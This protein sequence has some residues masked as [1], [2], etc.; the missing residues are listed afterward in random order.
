MITINRWH[1]SK[2]RCVKFCDDEGCHNSIYYAGV[3]IRH[4]TASGWGTS[5]KKNLPNAVISYRVAVSG[6]RISLSNYV[7]YN[8]IRSSKNLFR[9]IEIFHVCLMIQH[10]ASERTTDKSRY[11]GAM[12]SWNPMKTDSTMETITTDWL[13]FFVFN[14]VLHRAPD[15]H[16]ISRIAHRRH[17]QEKHCQ[18]EMTASDRCTS[19]FEIDESRRWESET[20]HSTACNTSR[21]RIPCI[22]YYW[23]CRVRTA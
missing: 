15:F 12:S 5:I 3:H 8:R 22:P 23:S 9:P 21:S 16:I 7:I 10:S 4:F 19:Y 6:V 17:I 20:F 11:V 1:V 14:P 13:Y 18:N 2:A